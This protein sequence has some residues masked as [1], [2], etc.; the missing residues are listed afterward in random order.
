M[1]QGEESKMKWYEDPV[2]IKMCSKAEEIQELFIG[3]EGDV[4]A[5]PPTKD[6]PQGGEYLVRSTWPFQCQVDRRFIWLPHQDQLQEM[7]ELALEPLINSFNC[8]VEDLP[9]EPDFDSME[10]LWLSYVMYGNFN[11]VW[12]GEEWIKEKI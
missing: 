2:Y 7:V 8:F 4:V 3:D 1:G 10:Q 12:D 9:D 11:K 5:Y 6:C